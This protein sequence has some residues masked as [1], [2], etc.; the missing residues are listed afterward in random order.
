WSRREDDKRRITAGLES[1]QR[2]V[3]PLDHRGLCDSER[4]H[5]IAARLFAAEEFPPALQPLWH[6]ER[7]NHDKIRLAYLSTDFPAHAVASLIVGIFEHH[8]KT[9]FETTAISFS[10]D[11]KSETR[12]RI[13]A[14]FDR[15]IDVQSMSDSQAAAIMRELEI[16][17]AIDLN[18]YT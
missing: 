7:C 17:I 16:D 12:S 2:V 15:F 5:L 11:D 9:Q 8:D 18:A 4:E 1:G 10:P 14:A 3:N 6:G 13:E